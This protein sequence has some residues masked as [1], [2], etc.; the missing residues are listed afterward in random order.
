MAARC[1][2]KLS[3]WIYPS[4]VEVAVVEVGVVVEGTEEEAEEGILISNKSFK[5]VLF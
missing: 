1:L 4:L 3:R 2:A 5:L